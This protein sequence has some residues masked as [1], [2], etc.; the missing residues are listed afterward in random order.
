[1]DRRYLDYRCHDYDL[2]QLRLVEIADA[3][4]FESLVAARRRPIRAQPSHWSDGG[5]SWGYIVPRSSKGVE[6]TERRQ[7]NHARSILAAVDAATNDVRDDAK[8]PGGLVRFGATLTVMPM[9]IEPLMASLSEV[10]SGVSLRVE[11]RLSP[12]LVRGGQWRA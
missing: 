7:I 11:E 1:M 5:P 10:A 2:R 3:E 12:H 9:L 6:R 4:V 8:E